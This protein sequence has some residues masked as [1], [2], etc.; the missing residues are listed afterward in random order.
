M[1]K[2][3]TNSAFAE[4]LYALHDVDISGTRWLAVMQR[5]AAESPRVVA[6]GHGDVGGQQLLADVRDYLEL[7]RDET[8]A[9]PLPKTSSAQVTQHVGTRGEYRRVVRVSICGGG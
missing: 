8:W 5:L 4:N 9:L 7:L 3:A 6:P 1:N 2:E